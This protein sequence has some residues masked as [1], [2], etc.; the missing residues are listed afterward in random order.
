MQQPVSATGAFLPCSLPPAVPC[1]LCKLWGCMARVPG[2]GAGTAGLAPH[3]H[4][5]LSTGAASCGQGL[6][7]QPPFGATRW[8][9]VSNIQLPKALNTQSRVSGGAVVAEGPHTPGAEQCSSRQARRPSSPQDGDCRVPH[10][11]RLGLAATGCLPR[12]LRGAGRGTR[13]HEA[14]ARRYRA[15]VNR[16]GKIHPVLGRGTGWGFR[17]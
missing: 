15:F 4:H 11:G 6:S 9:L 1:K 13:R 8:D 7:S 5:A 10:R 16:H 17:E 3:H 12:Q 14:Q 2:Q